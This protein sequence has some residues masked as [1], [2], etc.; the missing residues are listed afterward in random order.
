MTASRFC[1]GAR[2]VPA[3]I[4]AFVPTVHAAG[5]NELGLTVSGEIKFDYFDKRTTKRNGEIVKDTDSLIDEAILTL[6]GKFSSFPDV[7]LALATEKIR[8]SEYEPVFVKEFILTHRFDPNHAGVAGRMKLPFGV[9]HTA[10]V[11]DPQTKKIGQSETDA[12]L[13]TRGKND[14][15]GL[16]WNV[17]AFADDYR[18]REPG[19][20][21]VT[22]NLAWAPADRW[23][24][25]AGVISH[26][27]ARAD[28]PALANLHAAVRATS[29][30]WSGEYVAALDN[31]GGER[32]RALSLDG[33][34]RLAPR[35]SLGA[36]AQTAA[37]RFSAGGARLRYNEWAVAL[38]HAIST[39]ATAGIEYLRGIQR[40]GSVDV[41]RTG[42]I[43]ARVIL[44]LLAGK[45]NRF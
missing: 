16:T 14:A 22:A 18:T 34:F 44:S 29:W 27:Y 38:K 30:E 26:Q 19:A 9:F 37:R 24:V 10:T 2:L 5:E 42:Q 12:G 3:L 7:T 4:F 23:T 28:A 13:G 40:D 11:T 43:T 33:T 41:E 32:P 17:V 8:T 1:K 15:A 39:H 35:I 25:G 21:G 36:R 20:E 45:D 31:Q 6:D